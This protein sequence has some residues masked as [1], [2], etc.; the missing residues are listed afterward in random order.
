MWEVTGIIIRDQELKLPNR[1]HLKIHDL[2]QQIS[3]ESNPKQRAKLRQQLQGCVAQAQQIA[4]SN[5]TH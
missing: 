2:G 5:Q 4:A 1:Q 3:R